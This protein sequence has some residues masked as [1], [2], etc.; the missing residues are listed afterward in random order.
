MSDNTERSWWVPFEIGMASQNDFPIVTY[1]IN[2][3]PLPDYL[4]YW[5]TLKKYSDLATYISVKKSILLENNSS[6][7]KQFNSKNTT[8]SKTK[9]FYD[10]LKKELAY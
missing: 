6:I 5:P 1:L 3:V 2:N 9:Q 4:T 10:E 8:I 7:Y